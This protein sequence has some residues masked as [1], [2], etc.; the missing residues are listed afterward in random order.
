[1][2][3]VIIAGGKG[4]RLASVTGNVIPKPMVELCGKPILLNIVERLKENGIFEIYITVGYL[5]EV[6][7]DYFKDGKEFGVKIEYVI[8]NAELGTGGALF[9]LKDKIS[10]PFV[11]CYADT[12]FDIDISRMFRF[13]KQKNADFTLM[14]KPNN[15]P[16][17][18]DLVLADRNSKVTGLVLKNTSRHDYRNVVN[19]GLYIANPSVFY[20]FKE[21]V[22]LAI[23][24]DLIPALVRD[25]KN[26]FAYYTSEYMKDVG[27]PDRLLQGEEELK[28]GLVHAKNLKNKQK[29][30]FLDRDGVL[31]VYKGYITHPDQLELY[32][33][34]ID[35]IKK[36]NKSEY[37]AIVITNQPVLAR[38]DCSQETLDAIFRKL[39][40]EL[41]N[42]GAF[43]NKVYYCPHHPDKGFSGEVPAL[44]IEC[45]CRKPRTGMIKQACFD[46]NLDLSSCVMIG[47]DNRDL[48]M[49]QNAKIPAIFVESEAGTVPKFPVVSRAENLLQAINWFLKD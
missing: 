48:E 44:K 36:I 46:F 8:E 35:A 19:S 2:K 15:H 33:G 6:I 13:H 10:E 3:A 47:D 32:P 29:A 25:G 7:M 9:F 30:V 43:L 49:A 40:T 20:F 12:I 11:I 17:D 16:Y 38:G 4:T 39:D 1:M 24:R 23:D 42:Q 22:K 18:S 31:N 45:S 5:H 14:C 21:P 26:V 27:T 34:V 28:S 41:G 37:L